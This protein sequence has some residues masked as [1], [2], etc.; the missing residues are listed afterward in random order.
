MISLEFS[1]F[2]IR[3]TRFGACIASTIVGMFFLMG[4]ALA[5]DTAEKSSII[6]KGKDGWL[7]PRWGSLKIR[8]DAGIDN[9]SKLIGQAKE[10]LA[11]RGIKLEI[12]L[13]PDKIRFYQEK[14]PAED[15]MSPEVQQRYALIREKLQKMG[16]ETFDAEALLRQVQQSGQDVFYRTDQ[17]W[18]QA[19]ADA[20]AEATASMVK[21]DVPQ[22]AGAAGTGMALGAP[23]KERRYGDLADL[24][25]S[26]D[27]KK[28][29]GRDTFSVRKDSQS[30]SLLDDA[31]APVHVTGHSM[32]QPYF[33]FPQ[34]LSNVLDRPVSLNWKSGNVGPWVMLLEYVESTA[35]KQ[36]KPQVLVWQMFEPSYPQGPNA[37]GMWDNASIMTD[38]VW[39]SRFKSAV[40]G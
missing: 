35:F 20:V 17:H 10:I 5:A 38:E 24:F 4:T 6:I 9:A 11:S 36:Q 37:K 18:T 2:S 16:V 12:L 25:L 27:E 32:V 8:D 19:S 26:P 23:I 3:T 14:L 21:K 15:A 28:Q 34:K 40:G 31:P 29:I 7:F 39:L 22:L 1:K 33:G 13:L 30:A